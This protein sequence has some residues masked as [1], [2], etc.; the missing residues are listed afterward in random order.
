MTGFRNS[1]R[2]SVRIER[3]APVPPLKFL[4]TAFRIERVWAVAKARYV[5]QCDAILGLRDQ[6]R[7]RVMYNSVTQFSDFEP[8]CARFGAPGPNARASVRQT[9][10]AWSSFSTSTGRLAGTP[11]A[12]HVG[13]YQGIVISVSDSQ[14]SSSL[15]PFTIR[16][17]G[18]AADATPPSAPT[19][20]VASAS[21]SSRI[22]LGWSASSDNVAVTG[23][24]VFRCQGASCAP[25]AQVGSATGTSFGDSGLSA[26]TS[27]RYQVKAADA[28]GNVSAA[29]AIATAATAAAPPV[30]PRGLGGL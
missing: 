29:S 12:A 22:N 2:S 7:Q 21:G 23:Y 11:T 20:V 13:S 19:G 27:Y 10:P 4:L 8:E 17:A 26:G 9:R 14:A 3:Q 30:P 18:A 5:R 1:I 6:L 15:A 25:S 28:A 16:V 24:R